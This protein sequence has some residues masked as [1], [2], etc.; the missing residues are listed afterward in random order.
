MICDPFIHPRYYSWWKSS[1]ASRLCEMPRSYAILQPILVP[2][3]SRI[4]SKIR[5]LIL[6]PSHP[7]IKSGPHLHPRFYE[8]LYPADYNIAQLWHSSKL[9]NYKQQKYIRGFCRNVVTNNNEQQ[10][11]QNP[12]AYSACEQCMYINLHKASTKRGTGKVRNI[13]KQPKETNRAK[14]RSDQEGTAMERSLCIWS[15]QYAQRGA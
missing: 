3:V 14:R 5:R 1:R 2:H 13:K 6:S 10:T 12:K 7:A 4:Y 11:P 8:L 15:N 9:L